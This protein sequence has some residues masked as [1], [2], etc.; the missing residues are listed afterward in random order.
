M[1]SS[2]HAP[3]KESKNA[4]ADIWT[5]YSRRTQVVKR[6]E[7]WR[8]VAWLCTGVIQRTPR[9]EIMMQLRVIMQYENICGAPRSLLRSI[10]NL[11]SK[12]WNL[13]S[14][15]IKGS[16]K[17]IFYLSLLSPVLSAFFHNSSLYISCRLA[18]PFASRRIKREVLA[19]HAI[20]ILSLSLSINIIKFLTHPNRD[21]CVI[22]YCWWLRLM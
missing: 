5:F 8:H 1:R 21:K 16:G 15:V 14:G 3:A 9:V 18:Q 6:W 22:C 20:G 4:R 7:C 10:W 2:V 13:E 17:N 11:K 12:I 19:H